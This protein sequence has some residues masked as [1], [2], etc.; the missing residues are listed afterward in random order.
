MMNPR[1]RARKVVLGK[2]RMVRC[3]Y[4]L[5]MK[6]VKDITIDHVVPRS[7][8]GGYDR[9]NLRPACKQ[10]NERKG[11]KTPEEFFDE[12]ERERATG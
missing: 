8:G 5:E 3:Y 12:L 11:S 9:R 6:P 7:R 10:C 2:K 4:C 1:Q